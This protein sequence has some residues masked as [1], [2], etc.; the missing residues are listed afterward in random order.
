MKQQQFYQWMDSPGELGAESLGELQQ[1][2]ADVPYFQS[3]QI[4]YLLNLKKLGDYRFGPRLRTCA[5]YSADRAKLRQ[6]VDLIESQKEAT[7]ST[8]GRSLPDED[9]RLKSLELEIKKNLQEIAEKK[10]KLERLLE[11]KKS[12]TPQ[13]DTDQAGV[14]MTRQ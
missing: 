4:L 12:M 6:L 10:L 8:T 14:H 2:L 13:E 3:A 9:P 11:E 7:G 1:L 5:V